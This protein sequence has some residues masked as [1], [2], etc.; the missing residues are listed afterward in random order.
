MLRNDGRSWYFDESRRRIRPTNWD[1]H[2]SHRLQVIPSSQTKPKDLMFLVSEGLNPAYDS[3][4]I[5][6]Q[7][8]D[9]E[10]NPGPHPECDACR[11]KIRRDYTPLKCHHPGCEKGCHTG[12]KCSGISRWSKVRRWS[13]QQHRTT[14]NPPTATPSLNT[15]TPP[16]NT[17]TPALNTT[18]QRGKST[19]KACRITIKANTSPI[20]CIVCKGAYHKQMK[21]SG[22][23]R[24][25]SNAMAARRN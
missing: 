12:Q 23:T 15:T 17:T 16:H 18:T 1:R 2:A 25:A 10:T 11:K 3:R 21:C 9:I 20:T 24:D 4:S 7:A 22:L 5:L 13:C 14:T 6:L 8:G 19:C